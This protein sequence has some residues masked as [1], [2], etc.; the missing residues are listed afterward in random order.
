MARFLR[1]YFFMRIGILV[2][3][4]GSS[5]NFGQFASSAAP[6]FA[7]TINL[8]EDSGGEGRDVPRVK[9]AKK[10]TSEVWEHFTKY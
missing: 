4:E 3:S 8:D 10:V 2:P 6:T 5:Q 9:R 7:S 1:Q